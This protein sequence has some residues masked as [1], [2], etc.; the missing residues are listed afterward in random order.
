[1]S[2]RTPDSFISYAVGNFFDTFLV[3]W[4]SFLTV[5]LFSFVDKLP[6]TEDVPLPDMWMFIYEHVF[7]FSQWFVLILLG[8]YVINAF[9]QTKL[10]CRVAQ[11]VMHAWILDSVAIISGALLGSVYLN[12][13][14]VFFLDI[15]LNHHPI[16]LTLDAFAFYMVSMLAV[17]VI[18]YGVHRFIRAKPVIIPTT[19][20]KT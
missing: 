20:D 18:T 5:G 19:T 9:F 11:T 6:G 7:L 3:F 4:L 13:G 10:L 2:K 16:I 17:S 15:T 12:E 14:H 1:M 8:F